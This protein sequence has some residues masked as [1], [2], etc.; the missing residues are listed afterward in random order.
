MIETAEAIVS[1]HDAMLESL[2]EMDLPNTPSLKKMRRSTASA[3]GYRKRTFKSTL[4]RVY[5]L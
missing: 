2:A 1:T 3:I 4:L 5:S